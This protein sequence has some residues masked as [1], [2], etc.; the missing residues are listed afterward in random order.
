M[1]NLAYLSLRHCWCFSPIVF[2]KVLILIFSRLFVG[3]KH[4]QRQRFFVVEKH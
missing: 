1:I 2:F 4:Q 3:E